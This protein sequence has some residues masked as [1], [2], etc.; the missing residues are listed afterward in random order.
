[1]VTPATGRPYFVPGQKLGS[2][3]ISA[4]GFSLR[5]DV[6]YHGNDTTVTVN[7]STTGTVALESWGPEDACS[8]CIFWV[9]SQYPVI[10]E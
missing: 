1:M 6:R 2:G 10:Q 4:K 5:K 9:P 7:Y 3:L 8:M